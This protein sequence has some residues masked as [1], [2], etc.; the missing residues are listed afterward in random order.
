ME[1]LPT[2]AVVPA[3]LVI[4]FILLVTWIVDFVDSLV[5]GDDL[6]TWAK[7]LLGLGVAEGLCFLVGLNLFA[8]WTLTWPVAGIALSGVLLIAAAAKAAH[9]LEKALMSLAA[10][11]KSFLTDPLLNPDPP[12]PEEGD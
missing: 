8:Q 7:N 3:G 10:L 4:L 2:V 11:A 5:P 1:N 6:P 12:A 9:P